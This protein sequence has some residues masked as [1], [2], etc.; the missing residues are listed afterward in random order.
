MGAGAA[1]GLQ[2]GRIRIVVLRI[3]PEAFMVISIDGGRL[4]W[5]PA[6]KVAARA[7]ARSA[8]GFGQP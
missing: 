3:S 2:G 8:R 6:A 5:F 4:L 1:A 7:S